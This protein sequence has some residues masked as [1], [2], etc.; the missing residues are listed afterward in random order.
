MTTTEDERGYI[1]QVYTSVKTFPHVGPFPN[2]FLLNGLPHFI[3][4]RVPKYGLVDEMSGR[5]IFR[6][7]RTFILVF[8][9]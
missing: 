2:L 1:S 8:E 7:L 4:V 9:S 6:S 3:K 5:G